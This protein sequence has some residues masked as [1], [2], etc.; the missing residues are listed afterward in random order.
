MMGH[1]EK[2]K[3][4]DEYDAFSR[5]ARRIVVGIDRPGVTK[6]MKQ[7]FNQRV[8]KLARLAVQSGDESNG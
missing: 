4:G 7:K 3:G 1:R 6:R 5:R 8:R 2:M